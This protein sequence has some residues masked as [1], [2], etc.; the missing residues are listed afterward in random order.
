MRLQ[1]HPQVLDYKPGK[2]NFS[3]YTRVN[4]VIIP[5]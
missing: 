4:K 1:G 5:V 2:K 3:S